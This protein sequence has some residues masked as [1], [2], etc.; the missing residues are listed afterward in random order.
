MTAVFGLHDREAADRLAGTWVLATEVVDGVRSDLTGLQSEWVIRGRQV[1]DRLDGHEGFD[2][3][4]RLPPGTGPGPRALDLLERDG[5]SL[6]AAAVYVLDGDRLTIAF[7]R[8]SKKRPNK[9]TPE[10]DDDKV[11]R[12]YRRER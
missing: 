7:Y 6:A 1:T 4:F 10:A 2:T 3:T 9:L 12:V 8:E 5:R 11:V